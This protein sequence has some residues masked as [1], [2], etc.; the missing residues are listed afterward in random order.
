MLRRYYLHC[1]LRVPCSADSGLFRFES[2]QLLVE[3]L[4]NLSAEKGTV[5]SQLAIAWV[6]AKG[7]T[8]VPTIGARTRVQLRESLGALHLQLSPAEVARIEKAIPA[9]AVAGARYDEHHVK[10][11]DSE[12]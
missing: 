11:L 6:L 10:M 5:P 9:S 12:R 3:V 1:P 7:K 2:D 8:V 4:K